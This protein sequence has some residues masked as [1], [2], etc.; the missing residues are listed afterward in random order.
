VRCGR[1]EEKKWRSDRGN[2]NSFHNSTTPSLTTRYSIEG[3]GD[4][5]EATSN[6]FHNSTTP[7]LTTRYS[8]EEEE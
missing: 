8:I 1:R 5:A 7:S 6:S 4:K 2:S 3:G